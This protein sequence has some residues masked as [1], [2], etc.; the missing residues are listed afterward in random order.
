MEKVLN[1]LSSLVNKVDKWDIGKIR[2]T[3]V[4]LSKQSEVIKKNALDEL[5][6]KVNLI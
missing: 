4:D 5:F 1:D 3:P 6:K 2:I